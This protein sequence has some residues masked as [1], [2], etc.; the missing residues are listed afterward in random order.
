MVL[1]LLLLLLL[2]GV[3][4]ALTNLKSTSCWKLNQ[5]CYILLLM[6]GVDLLFMEG[7]DLLFCSVGGYGL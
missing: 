3:D 6:E 1:F 4:I 2:S 7:V 5:V